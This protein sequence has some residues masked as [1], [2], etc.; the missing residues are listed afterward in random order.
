MG[1]RTH[2]L[3][4]MLFAGFFDQVKQ[5]VLHLDRVVQ[6]PAQLAG[7]SHTDGVDRAHAQLDLARD[8]PREALVGKGGF[9]VSI[10]NNFAQQVARFGAGNGK[11][12]VLGGYVLNLDIAE[13]SRF[14]SGGFAEIVSVISCPSPCA[15][16]VIIIG[17][18]THD[19]IFGARGARLCQ[20][21]GQVYPA[22]AWQLVTGE[23]V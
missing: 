7:I 15:Y 18:L 11:H 4:A 21:I 19:G 8:Q 20:R 6:L 23:P 10:H 5:V 3:E 2:Q 9:G 1:A 13:L 12:A 22:H 14:I 16:E 17:G